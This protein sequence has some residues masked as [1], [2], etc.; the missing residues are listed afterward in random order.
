MVQN[1]IRESL[2]AKIK[3]WEIRMRSVHQAKKAKK[4]TIILAYCK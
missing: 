1:N 3:E 4:P 2:H